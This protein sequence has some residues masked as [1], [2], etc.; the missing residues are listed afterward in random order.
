MTKCGF[1][2]V[3]GAPNVGKSTLVNAL[4][5]SKVTIVSPKVQTTR[6]R[7]LGIALEKNA[8]VIFVDTPGIFETPKRRLEKAMVKNA[9]ESL[10]DADGIMVLVDVSRKTFEETDLILNHLEK[11]KKNVV[12][13]LNKID[14]IPRNRLLSIAQHFSRPN[15]EYTFMISALKRDGIYDIKKYWANHVPEGPWLFPKDQ[16]SDLPQKLLAAEI[17][18][19][20]LFHRLHQELP[21]S[22]WVETD[23]WEEFKNGSVKIIQSI[24]VQRESQRVIVLGKGGS[25]VKAIGEGARKQLSHILGKPVHL[26]LHVK[27]KEGW[28]DNP[29]LYGTI[30]L[31]FKV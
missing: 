29:R 12:I 18:R 20:E 30:G 2:V 10:N 19:E 27:V 22:I 4:V 28:I 16:L 13:V 23:Q 14:L 26:F 6:S 11:K 15:V 25:L 9:W 8:Q 31:N 3:I 1:I 21:Y 24:Y 5:G 7:I 17:T